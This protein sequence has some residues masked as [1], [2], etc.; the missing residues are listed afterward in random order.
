MSA[1]RSS[2]AEAALW[3]LAQLS[4]ETQNRVR[5]RIT[6]RVDPPPSPAQTRHRELAFVADLLRSAATR[7]GWSFPYV[8]RSEH[9]SLRPAE[10]PSSAALV[11]RY[12]SWVDVCRHANH[13]VT[14]TP[15]RLPKHRRHANTKDA[16]RYTK[17]EAIAALHECAR[18]LNRT[19]STTAYRA[20][21][22]AGE[23]R[24]RGSTTYPSLSVI[25]RLYAE[26]GGWSAALEDADL[27]T[28]PTTTI[29]VVAPNRK[30]AA[31][32]AAALQ[33][34]GLLAAH[35]R[36]LCWVEVR[37]S[38]TE[39]RRAIRESR[40]TPEDLFIW[41]PAARTLEA[42]TLTA[43]RERLVRVPQG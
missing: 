41:D 19:P 35:A 2:D 28:A 4:S 30:Q 31:E 17:K 33:A 16:H 21:R 12:G 7:P 14:G 25:G 1:C 13:L 11:E 18:E 37:A 23:R 6:L 3:L 29:R 32:T 34:H 5:R 38:L 36:N 9:D 43:A 22:P 10:S 15:N 39:V 26:R 20:W 42:T 27:V 8:S 24:R 40:S